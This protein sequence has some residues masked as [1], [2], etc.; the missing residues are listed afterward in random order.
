MS[1]TETIKKSGKFYQVI[2]GQLKTRELPGTPGAEARI[3][4]KGVEVWESSH[5]ALF[6]SITGIEIV[7]SEYG[8]NLH[9]T[10]DPNEDNETPIISLSLNSREGTDAMHKLPNVD[11]SQDVRISPYRF[12]PEGESKEKSGLS[13]FQRNEEGKFEVKIGSAFYGEGNTRL[14]G[15]PEIDWDNA[16]ES[17]KKIHWIK[18]GDFL[19]TY[20]VAN[21]IGKVQKPVSQEKE[22]VSYPSEEIDASQIPW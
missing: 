17:D 20:L 21:V 6:G 22:E 19:E 3:N 9:I 7:D 12:T 5:R 13:I 10:L 4:K 8:K 15:F 1:S 16:S 18:V 2:G 11:L 14:H